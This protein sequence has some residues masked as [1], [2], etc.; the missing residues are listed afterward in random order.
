M[1]LY[2]C[3]YTTHIYIVT[4]KSTKLALGHL[5]KENIYI[6][7]IQIYEIEIHVNSKA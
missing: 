3:L 4:G 2:V 1:Y 5:Y 6:F 7:N